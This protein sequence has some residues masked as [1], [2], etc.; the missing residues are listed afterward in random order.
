MTLLPQV[1]RPQERDFVKLVTS[2]R[3]TRLPHI[4][5]IRFVFHGGAF[6]VLTGSGASDWAKN[7]VK[8]ADARLRV[9]E[10][11]YE[12]AVTSASSDERRRTVEDFIKKYGARLVS[13]WYPNTSICLKLTPVGPPTRRGAAKG[14]TEPESDFRTWK[15]QKLDYYSG[16]VAAFD[17]AAE[18]YDFTI[19][20]N[21]INRWI[22][23]KAIKELLKLTNKRD[24]LLEI[25][26]GTGAEAIALAGEVSEI[27]ATDISERM[28]HILEMKVGAKGFGGR[29][30]PFRARASEIS[31]VA[32][33]LG[34][35]KV[36]VA[37]SFNGALNC[38]PELEHF[39]SALSTIME[40]G[41]FFVCSIRNTLCLSE[42]V[43][44]GLALQ[45]D[46]MAPRKK[47]PLMVSVGGRDIPST[48]YS[49]SE[50]IRLFSSHFELKRL[51]GLPAILPPAYL[52]DRYVRLRNI[53]GFV[54]RIEDVISSRFPFNRFGDQSLFVFQKCR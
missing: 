9:D 30:I 15:A 41:G 27:I 46:K 14:E 21:F 42:A 17:S 51:I 6:Y 28:L 34:D 25:G 49:P 23:Q 36:R 47:Q 4:V 19:S 32:S 40:E 7:A 12:V 26:C 29:I 53:V 43:L 48:Y 52:S 2:G 5:V 33:F 39:P 18:E 44:H 20:Q 11:V 38:E 50:F 13:N 3:V 54:E 16:V 10:L 35:R 8:S 31:R 22:R 24:T 1:V 45:F 37:Y